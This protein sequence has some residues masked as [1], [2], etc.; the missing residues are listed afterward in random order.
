[1]IY[2]LPKSTKTLVKQTKPQAGEPNKK[3]TVMK[4]FSLFLITIHENAA[5]NKLQQW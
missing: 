1:M 5:I 2:Y 3:P 4:T